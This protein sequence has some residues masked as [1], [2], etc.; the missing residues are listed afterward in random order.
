MTLAT[1]AAVDY[2]HTMIHTYYFHATIVDH[3]YISIDYMRLSSYYCCCLF[4]VLVSVTCL[5]PPVA[6]TE[7]FIYVS[8]PT[9]F[10]GV[11]D[12]VGRDAT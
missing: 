12:D 10:T 2:I 3:V 11:A 8:Y 6:P 9:F 4:F 1:V 7:K 5:R